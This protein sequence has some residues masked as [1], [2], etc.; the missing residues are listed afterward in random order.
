MRRALPIRFRE[1]INGYL[2]AR[3]VPREKKSRN[4]IEDPSGPQ[5][6][7]AGL[8]VNMS[9]GRLHLRPGRA[10]LAAELLPEYCGELEQIDPAHFFF[11]HNVSELVVE[12]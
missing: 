11:S 5:G 6:S 1:A 2:N 7:A 10:S 9:H 12:S 8:R 4:S 3:S